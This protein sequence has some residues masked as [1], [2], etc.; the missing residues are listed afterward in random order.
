MAGRDEGFSS[1]PYVREQLKKALLAVAVDPDKRPPI[2][3]LY[4]LDQLAQRYHVWT[5]EIE[6]D[7]DAERVMRAMEFARL[8]SSVIVTGK[9][10]TPKGG[11]DPASSPRAHAVIGRKVDS[12]RP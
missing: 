10:P 3:Y 5:R 7:P 9:E 8:E 1:P 4:A 12:G 2:P 11:G 6:E